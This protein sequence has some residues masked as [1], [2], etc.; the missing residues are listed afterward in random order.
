MRWKI[1]VLGS[2]ALAAL[3]TAVPGAT[4]DR[5]IV[6]EA[7]VTVELLPCPPS[8][9][10][11]VSMPGC[12]TQAKIWGNPARWITRSDYPGRASREQWAGVVRF[13]LLADT[14]KPIGGDPAA[15]YRAGDCIIVRSSGRDDLDKGTCDILKRRVVFEATSVNKV[16]SGIDGRVVWVPSWWERT[17][18]P[19]H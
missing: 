5:V 11:R 12:Y 4:T 14:T 9:P 10:E 8:Q 13:R 3:N 7:T 17:P 18:Q 2:L 19:V 1:S 6:Q 16:R 15:G